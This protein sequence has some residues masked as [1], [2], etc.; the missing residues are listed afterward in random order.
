LEPPI[1]YLHEGP[2]PK[3]HS[4]S[5]DAVAALSKDNALKLLKS[6]LKDKQQSTSDFEDIDGD[7]ETLSNSAKETLE[8]AGSSNANATEIYYGKIGDNELKNLTM[9]SRQVRRVSKKPSF[10]VVEVHSSSTNTK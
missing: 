9:T 4:L 5:T 10:T 7:V 6:D 3:I 1:A 2:P 8:K